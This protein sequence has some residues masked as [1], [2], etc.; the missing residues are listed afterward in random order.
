MF[1]RKYCL[2]YMKIKIISDILDIDRS[3]IFR[4][5]NDIK[6][7]HDNHKDNLSSLSKYSHKIRFPEKLTLIKVNITPNN[8]F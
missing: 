8:I 7:S 1:F 4:W 6:S 2:L 3:T 5:I